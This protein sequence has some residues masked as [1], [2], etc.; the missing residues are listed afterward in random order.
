[1]QR[2]G[3]CC[4]M[5]IGGILSRCGAIAVIVHCVAPVAPAFGHGGGLDRNGCHN[6]KRTGDYHCHRD[7]PGIPVQPRFL[8]APTP[9][10][11]P[12]IILSPP[13]TRDSQFQSD[14]VRRVQSGLI[15]LG[16]TLPEPDNI[17]GPLTQFAIMKFEEAE[18]LKISGQPTQTLVNL[19]EAKADAKGL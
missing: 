10:A 14:I 2:K 18:G 6:N 13:V 15:R 8:R 11:A 1:M 5:A 16:Y 12:P 7:G 19:I 17:L 3:S 9:P 4:L